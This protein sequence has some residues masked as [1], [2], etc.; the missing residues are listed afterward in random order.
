MLLLAVLLAGTVVGGARMPEV[1]DKVQI[2]QS[3]GTLT[4]CTYGKI[5]DVNW[6]NN[7][8]QIDVFWITTYLGSNTTNNPKS[9]YSNES[10]YVNMNT[11]LA[12][13]VYT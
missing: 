5:T 13:K 1:G 4:R 10:I 11:V 7:L 8:I 2:M 9:F 12:L 6:E 3:Q